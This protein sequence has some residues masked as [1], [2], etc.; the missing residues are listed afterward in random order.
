MKRLISSS[1]TINLDYP[2]NGQLKLTK[3]GES[4]S[5]STYDGVIWRQVYQANDGSYWMKIDNVWQEVEPN[6]TGYLK[7]SRRCDLRYTQEEKDAQRARYENI[8]NG[9]FN[10]LAGI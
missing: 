8:D 2:D 5:I 10:P 6:P 1:I 7:K 3:T 4:H 9:G